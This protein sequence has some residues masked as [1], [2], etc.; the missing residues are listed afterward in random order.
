[1]NT[2]K[3]FKTL[4]GTVLAALLATMS[5]AV[6]SAAYEP[7]TLSYN[8]TYAGSHEG[9]QAGWTLD[10]RGGL[11]RTTIYG[12][13]DTLKDT[14]TLRGSSLYRDLNRMDEG[15]ATLETSLLFREGFDGLKLILTDAD[16]N[17][18]YQLETDDGAFYLSEADGRK[19]F[20]RRRILWHAFMFSLRSILKPVGRIPSLPIPIAATAIFCRIISGA[21]L[22]PPRPRIP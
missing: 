3:R 16:G 12:G 15:V 11:L 13:Y 8:S 2:P 22:L 10:N 18:T 1:M 19:S 14:S 4:C 5:A 9:I 6:A 20:I 17:V 7:Y 21:S